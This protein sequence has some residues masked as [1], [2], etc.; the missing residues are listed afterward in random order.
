M[1]IVPAKGAGWTAG[2]SKKLPALSWAFNSAS[3]RVR[4]LLSAHVASKKAGRSAGA[5]L[6]GLK[7]DLFHVE[8]L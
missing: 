6:D 5:F 2:P 1:V 3:T 4:T 8:S 7:K